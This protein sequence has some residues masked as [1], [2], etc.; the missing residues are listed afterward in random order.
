MLQVCLLL[1]KELTLTIGFA[2]V[3]VLTTGFANVTVLL[4]QKELTLTTIIIC[5]IESYA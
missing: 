5:F 4:F 3:T 1:E 2:N